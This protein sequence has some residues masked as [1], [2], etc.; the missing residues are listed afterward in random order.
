[1]PLSMMRLIREEVASVSPDKLAKRLVI[2]GAGARGVILL[3]A[4]D[5]LGIKPAYFVDSNSA[6]QGALVYGVPVNDPGRIACENYDEIFVLTAVD[7]PSGVIQTLKGFGLEHGTHFATLFAGMSKLAISQGATT[8][9]IDFFLGFN[10]SSDLP[11]FTYVSSSQ[12]HPATADELTIITLGNS[13]TDHDSVDPLDWKDLNRRAKCNGSWPR[14]LHD[15]L[16][17]YGIKNTIINGGLS[18]YTSGQELLKLIRDCLSL[19][20]DIVIVCDGINDAYASKWYGDKYPKYHHY[21]DIIDKSLMQHINDN[22]IK[23]AMHDN[24]NA[25]GISYG[26]ASNMSATDEWYANH[27]M[28]RAVCT[29]FGIQHVSFLQPAGLLSGQYIASCD[30]QFRTRWFLWNFLNRWNDALVQEA[31]E[32][33]VESATLDSLQNQLS[34]FVSAVFDSDIP[35]VSFKLRGKQLEAFYRQAAAIASRSDFIIDISSVLDGQPDAYYDIIHCTTNGNKIIAQ[36]IYEELN[37]SGLLQRAIANRAT[38]Q[39]ANVGS[40]AHGRLE[41]LC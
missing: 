16:M 21:F 11:G 1:M 34:S 3:L 6:R 17:S 33:S 15:I 2:Y 38:R 18:G 9:L 10:R 8:P 41:T 35:G 31:C 4:L 26:L 27:R 30:V 13:T 14:F 23:M 20:P 25:H 19:K 39:I 40:M 12:D 29:E 5:S 7:S 37:D 36:R 24:A 32:K 28:M 22:K